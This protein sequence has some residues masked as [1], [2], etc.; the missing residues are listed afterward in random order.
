MKIRRNWFLLKGCV[1]LRLNVRLKVTFTANIYTPCDREMVLLQLCRW[2]FSH[3]ETFVE[4]IIR[5]NL[6]FIHK[7]DNF[8]F[9]SHTLG[10][11][12]VT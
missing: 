4:D 11:L 5:L 6:T 3:K 12:G 7:N 2:K 1:I 10:E 8:A 9:L